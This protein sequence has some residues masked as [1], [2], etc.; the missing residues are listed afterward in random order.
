M[1]KLI[2]R[3][4]MY[5]ADKIPDSWF[6]KV[7]GGFYKN[8]EEAA[9]AK[10]AQAKNGG[11]SSRPGTSGSGSGS[12]GGGGGRSRRS[13]TGDPKRRPPPPDDYDG[14][15]GGRRAGGNRR[16]Q[17]RSPYDGGGDDAYYSG[18]DRHRRRNH[19][20]SRRRRSFDDDRYGYDDGYGRAP[21]ED[22]NDERRA[23]GRAPYPQSGYASPQVPPDMYG[24]AAAGA[25]AGLAATGAAPYPPSNPA[26]PPPQ[27]TQPPPNGKSGGFGNAYVP[28]ANIYG[29]PAQ[30]A[31]RHPFSPPSS[32][33]GSVQPNGANQVAPPPN[34][35]HQNANAQQAATAAAAGAGAAYT[36][37]AGPY[38]NGEG[39][40]PRY[41][42]PPYDHR[43]DDRYNGYDEFGRPY[44]LSPPT[45]RHGKSGREYSPPYDSS[46]RGDPDRQPRSD[47]RS[48]GDDMKRTKSQGAGARGKH[49]SIMRST[50]DPSQRGLGYGAVGALAGGWSAVR[51]GR[52]FCRWRW[53]LRSVR[54]VLM[55]LKLG[56]GTYLR[57]GRL[58]RRPIRRR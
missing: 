54:S 18:D 42:D 7:P 44:P 20:S 8:K 48:G 38:R 29:Q 50:F 49:L 58:A 3:S 4:V 1:E 14:A 37:Q 30:Q 22:R 23:N 16:R 35:Y 56:R 41:D 24:P 10:K 27:S 51:W 11:S 32:A 46:S 19:G 21:R 47:H 34:N 13:S 2:L 43:Y 6:E 5:G 31:P 17:E 45:S 12:G 26:S 39:Y 9:R 53:G 25:A 40:D 33:N 15:E 36:G 28:Y 57:V 55:P 52:G